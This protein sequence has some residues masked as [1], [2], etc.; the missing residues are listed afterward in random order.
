MFAYASIKNL[1]SIIENAGIVFDASNATNVSYMFNEAS[2][3]V[4]AP[5]IDATNATSIDRLFNGCSSLE[6][7]S[8]VFPKSKPTAYT[9][10]FARC[11]SLEDFTAFG[12]ISVPLS[13]SDSPLLTH[14]SLMSIINALKDYSGSDTTYTVTLGRE[15]LAKLTDAEK[16][17]AVNK[18]WTLVGWTPPE[19]FVTCPTCGAV[20]EPHP[21][22]AGVLICPNCGDF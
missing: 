21:E 18:G 14:D 20:T 5:T 12:E 19:D 11:A 9:N 22:L 1:A 7:A 8:V 10:V 6:K 2:A 16:M 4:E 15:N 17:M 3:L 13:F